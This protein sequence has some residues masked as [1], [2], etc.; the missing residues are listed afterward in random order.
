MKEMMVGEEE[1]GGTA[2]EMEEEEEEEA[3]EAAEV[4]V[5]E[6]E[7]MEEK[8]VVEAA[9]QELRMIEHG[10]TACRHTSASTRQNLTRRNQLH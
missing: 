8:V 2:E 5:V 1:T 7:E 4:M 3:G 6:V 9:A 10:K